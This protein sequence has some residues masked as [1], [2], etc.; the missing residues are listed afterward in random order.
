[1]QKIIIKNFR[2]ISNAEIEVKDFLFLIGEQASGKST[3]AKLIYFFKSL[4]QDY[5]ELMRKDAIKSNKQFVPNLI[6]KIQDKFAVYFGYTSG[7]SDDFYIEYFF[8]EESNYSLKL[9]KAKRLKVEFEDNFFD[10]ITTKTSELT[11]R[12]NISNEIQLSFFL[13]GKYS[14]LLIDTIKSVAN[15]VFFDDKETLFFPAGRNIT[16]SYPEQFQLLFFSEL[17]KQTNTIDIEL[18]RDF[19]SYSKFLVD[20]FNAENKGISDTAFGKLV[21]KIISQ[22]LHGEYK[23]DNGREKLFYGKNEYVPLNI[24][25]S[26]QQEAIRIIQDAIYILSEKQKSSRIIEEPETHL[27]PK[28]Q[29]LLIEL[30]ILVA[31]K[32]NSQI[33]ITTHSPHVM[34]TFNNM[35]YY[36]KVL[37]EQ[38][39]KRETI[40]EFFSTKG[41]NDQAKAKECMNVDPEKFQAYRLNVDSEEYCKSIFDSSI[42]LIGENSID[43]ETENINSE[44]D[45][46]YSII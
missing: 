43:Q 41:L 8:S 18:I 33:I 23:N 30:L 29:K 5:I 16:V 4:K 15:E 20:Y 21:L 17:N 3:I 2:Q 44:F 31:N 26:G 34:A 32:T 35:L 42:Q 11:E 24:A 7:L 22:I 1:M 13:H 6:K 12:I 27:F 14:T 19:I 25:S 10:F 40:E 36:T 38:P 37:K 45:F 28:A 9:Y 39:S 46:L